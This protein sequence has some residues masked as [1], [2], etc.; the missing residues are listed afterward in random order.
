[1]INS[2]EKFEECIGQCPIRNVL[3][4][5]GD[6]WSMLVLLYLGR[7]DKMR[8]NELHKAVGD[9][10]QKMLTV[11]LK[12]LEADGLVKRT[13]FPQIPPRVEYNLTERGRSLIPHLKNLSKWAEDNMV[14][15]QESRALKS[16]ELY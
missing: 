14:G 3:D 16:K 6:K 10:S 1:M 15:I 9:I 7:T 12:I 8:F 5:I 13:M 11:T 2:E 4:R